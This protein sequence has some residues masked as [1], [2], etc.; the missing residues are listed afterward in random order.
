MRSRATLFTVIC[1]V[2]CAAVLAQAQE[3][4][5][6]EGGRGGRGGQEAAQPP[7]TDKVTPE[8]PGIVKA[9]TKIEIVASGLRG[10]DAGVGLPDGSFIA[11]ANGGVVKF[12]PDGK[13]TTLVE[14][15]EQAA[16]LAMDSKGRL[17]G[18][19]YTKK[20]SVL[21]PKGSEETLTSSFDGKP[22]I[23][24]NDIVV[25]KKGGVYFTDCYQI[26][27]T[28]SP[29]DLPQS[30][31][32]IAPNKKVIR[33][34]DDVRR[35]NGIVLSPDEKTL[36]V[37]DWDSPYLVSYEIQGDG[38]LKNRKNFAM[39]DVKQETDHGLVSGAD[40]LCIDGAG[41]TF[42]TTPAGV[43][44]FDAKGKHL[45]NIDAPYDMPPQNCG[46]GGPGK[47]YLYVTGRGA[48]W[49]V[50]TLNAGVKNRGK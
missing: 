28:R 30:V 27:A 48:V 43:Q 12:D 46:F 26:G 23:R 31:Y 44:V 16:G 21:Y 11:T 9:G 10:S 25:D 4:Q 14:D 45:G 35:P 8:I 34:A 41:N 47:R 7:A 32:Y 33:V 6:R 29:N 22:Y 1:L 50:Q 18:A 39:M 40:G 42:A 20:V 5:G 19:Q 17:F 15:S 49:R 37:N 2:C 38:T 24:P 13:M 36:Y 3:R